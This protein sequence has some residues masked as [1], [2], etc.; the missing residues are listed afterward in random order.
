MYLRNPPYL[1]AEVEVGEGGVAVGAREAVGVVGA[2]AEVMG[3]VAAG[4]VTVGVVASG[5]V[6]VGAVGVGVEVE[7][8]PVII[9]VTIKRTIKKIPR[10][11]IS[12]LQSTH[13]A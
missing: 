7:L 8:Q 12:D 2:G 13:L 6:T 4:V 5:A 1:A 11:R 9:K 3:V 10:F